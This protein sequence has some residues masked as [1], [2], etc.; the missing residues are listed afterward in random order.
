MSSET[1]R[2][3]L[4]ADSSGNSPGG[5][6]GHRDE[7]SIELLELREKLGPEAAEV[8]ELV[9]R[10]DGQPG[11][12]GRM[13]LT[14]RDLRASERISASDMAERLWNVLP[15]ADRQSITT[16]RDL[17]VARMRRWFQP[18]QKPFASLTVAQADLL[19][20]AAAEL[21]RRK[22]FAPPSHAH[23]GQRDPTDH[24]NRMQ[25]QRL[26]PISLGSYV[27]GHFLTSGPFMARA[28]EDIAN[29]VY[30]S[31]LAEGS[32]SHELLCVAGGP[33]AGK[34]SILSH[35]VQRYLKG[36]DYKLPIFA[37]MCEGLPCTEVGEQLV[38]LLEG[39]AARRSGV[40][41]NADDRIRFVRDHAAKPAIY[42][43]ADLAAL[44][45][46]PAYRLITRQDDILELL[47]ILLSGHPQT[48]V[49][50]SCEEPPQNRSDTRSIGDGAPSYSI[51]TPWS[52]SG[53]WPIPKCRLIR[54]APPRMQ[55][56][57]DTLH[58][59]FG[60]LL[61]PMQR[62]RD[63]VVDGVALHLAAAFLSLHTDQRTFSDG[64]RQFELLLR[65]ARE[66]ATEL[67]RDVVAEKL[68][69]LFS[70]LHKVLCAI[71]A[72]S[73]DGVRESSLLWLLERLSVTVN[74]EEREVALQSLDRAFDRTI[75]Q[76]Y[77]RLL[78]QSWSTDD[79]P[80]GKNIEETHYQLDRATR[81]AILTQLENGPEADR[82]LAR[83]VHRL[84][85]ARARQQAHHRRLT[86]SGIYG[87]RLRD[88]TR[89]VQ[90]VLSL[91]ASVDLAETQSGSRLAS[92]IELERAVLDGRVSGRTA[93]RFAYL[94]MWRQDI[95]RDYR[96]STEHAAEEL[97]LHV[98][99]AIATSA[100]KS[101]VPRRL[102]EVA[103]YQVTREDL[104]ALRP[105]FSDDELLELLAS[106][107]M[108]A[109]QV[110][111]VKIVEQV[112]NYL[113]SRLTNLSEHHA[114]LA[115]KIQRAY[116]DT[117]L[118][119]GHEPYLGKVEAYVREQIGLMS[120]EHPARKQARLKLYLRLGEVC[121]LQG[122]EL[123]DN[124]RTKRDE[125]RTAFSRAIELQTELSDA[126]ECIPG[127][128]LISGYG[129]RRFVRALLDWA[130]MEARARDWEAVDR[131]LA[132]AHD[133]HVVS[134]RRLSRHAADRTAVLLD[135]AR[136]H[137]VEGY[138]KQ[139]RHDEPTGA[140]EEY[141]IARELV[142]KAHALRLQLGIPIAVR[143]D[144]DALVARVGLQLA[145]VY[146]GDKP[147]LLRECEDAALRLLGL[148]NGIDSK[149]HIVHA[150]LLVF[151]VRLAQDEL[152]A[153][154]QSAY[155]DP[156]LLRGLRD[157]LNMANEIGLGI[158]RRELETY[159]RN[160]T[161]EHV[162]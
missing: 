69:A 117:L 1:Q 120:G 65:E 16:N 119:L 37:L 76:D 101:F 7:F 30:S 27:D 127:R 66:S 17:F 145:Q 73:D 115:A 108:A 118:Q 5:G 150:R 78:E 10:E 61:I 52:P 87:A 155:E 96:L 147:A 42:V 153:S 140:C 67:A 63:G 4:A 59:R 98:L 149:I 24:S 90:A 106:L 57:L 18:S 89:D 32:A 138:V 77:P 157:A 142:G 72:A 34:K 125:A 60:E 82:T 109:Q 50:I 68:W 15:A 40:A 133:I 128:P 55:M 121:H 36:E 54:L 136:F 135:E 46:D 2:T 88:L 12:L 111:A 38:S 129:A 83:R 79:L 71:I 102:L 93:L 124:G 99:V 160:A 29:Q 41:A 123:A 112:V 20:A 58:D 100:G 8:R 161:G 97:R 122:D 152:R 3:P 114:V 95:D 146:D 105:V 107:A 35:V 130:M 22:S 80:G 158:Y 56:L 6:S 28:R 33:Y 144:L 31:Y 25:T 23:P 49:I 94:Q 126:E 156:D 159:L 21:V 14:Y 85:A 48:R 39:A 116:I 81:L 45:G 9:L 64:I 92:P 51:I 75:I 11:P 113:V 47:G 148:A 132:E 137:R 139:H 103:E 134:L 110:G 131:L 19:E 13:V 74:D 44:P 84:I 104:D 91:V 143:L 70:P 141:V 53:S 162:P 26:T 62:Y 151:R 154:A 43:L 86:A